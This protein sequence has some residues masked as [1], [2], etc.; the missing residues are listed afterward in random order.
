MTKRNAP[1][2]TRKTKEASGQGKVIQQKFMEQRVERIN[3][4]PLKPWNDEQKKYLQYLDSKSIIIATGYPGTSKTYLPTAWACDKYRVGDIDKIYLVR[5]ATSKSKS[6]GYFAGTLQEKS[7]VW[8]G[9]VLSIFKDRLG[10]DALEIAIKR[11]DLEFVPLE[12]LKGR[13][14]KNC[15]VLVEEAEDITI[16]EARKLVTR[17]GDNCTMILSG[18]IGQS[19]LSGTSG[20]KFLRE[21]TLKNPELEKFTGLVDFNRPGDIVRSE[22]CKNWT[23]ALI[24][25]GIGGY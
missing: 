5:P 10:P 25:E 12:T 9:E 18:D 14:L 20:L 23:L 1:R 15:I 4:A 19:D 2:N 6:L 8:L 16:E 17:V 11:G 13:S 22:A 7:A 24:R 21:V 3:A